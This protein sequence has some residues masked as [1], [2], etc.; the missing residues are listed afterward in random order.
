MITR[1]R[2][3]TRVAAAGGA[4]LGYE[5]MTGLGLLAAPAQ[6]PFDLT[7]RVV[8][9]A[10]RDSRRRTGRADRRLRARQSRL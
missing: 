2:F 1:R 9:V 10:C 3:L 8:G 4:S 5:A 6:A 7:G